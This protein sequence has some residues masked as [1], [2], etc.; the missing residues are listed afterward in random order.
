MSIFFKHFLR[1]VFIW[2]NRLMFY[3][4]SFAIYQIYKYKKSVVEEFEA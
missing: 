1:H 4:S 2:T 3:Y